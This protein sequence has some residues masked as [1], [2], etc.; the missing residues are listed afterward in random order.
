[1]IIQVVDDPLNIHHGITAAARVLEAEFRIHGIA[2]I[3]VS[4][5][6]FH[7]YLEQADLTTQPYLLFHYQPG[8]FCGSLTRRIYNK[9]RLNFGFGLLCITAFRYHL[10]FGVIVHEFYPDR[11]RH[12][13]RTLSRL[14]DLYF[15]RQAVFLFCSQ[16]WLNHWLASHGC[17]NVHCQTIFSNLPNPVSYASRRDSTVLVYFGSHGSFQ[18]LLAN[19]AS[20]QPILCQFTDSP[21]YILVSKLSDSD[22]RRAHS[23]FHYLDV[24]CMQ[25]LDDRIVADY[26]AKATVG[27][28]DYSQASNP[29]DAFAKSGVIASYLQYGVLPL[30]LAE[31]HGFYSLDLRPELNS[32]SAY[33]KLSDFN[34]RPVN[35]RLLS[36][37]YTLFLSVSVYARR[38]LTQLYSSSSC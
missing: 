18:R 34:L 13:G 15:L 7:H 1:M 20:W 28:V 14:V 32:Q 8:F 2:S 38:V 24:K 26:L 4:V 30:I 36:R 5:K 23:I 22:L 37:H 31:D 27:I 33:Y 11:T 17:P 3:V 9:T 6:Q 21:F 16:K 35:S 12:L 29:P 25:G 19:S 10:P